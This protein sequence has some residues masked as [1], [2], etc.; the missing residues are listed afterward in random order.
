[1]IIC[2]DNSLPVYFSL[3]DINA[4]NSFEFNEDIP[5]RENLLGDCKFKVSVEGA[6]DDYEKESG[7]FKIS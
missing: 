7:N 1:M 6:V 4:G 5:T 2:G 3:A